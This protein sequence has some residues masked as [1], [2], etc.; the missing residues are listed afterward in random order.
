MQNGTVLRWHK[1]PA[2]TV[3]KGQ[4][5]LDVEVERAI[6]RIQADRNATVGEILAPAGTTVAVGQPLA[7]MDE[8][9]PAPAEKPSKT[10]TKEAAMAEP[11]GKVIPILMPQAGNTM[12]EGT[13]IKWHVKVGDTI[14]EGALIFDVET[15]KAAVEIEALD[16]GRLARIT[17]EE[18]EIMEVLKPVAYIADSDED[19][20]AYLASQGKAAAEP[21]QQAAAEEKAPS[22][23]AAKPQ[24]TAPAATSDSG[25]VKA[26]PAA[27]KTAAQRGVDIATVGA[28][29]GPGGRILLADVPAGPAAGAVADGA[30]RQKM[31]PMRRAIG[32]ALQT[33]KQT[34]PHFYIEL[35]VDADAMMDFYRQEKAEY[36][37]SLNDVVLLACAKTIAEFPSFRSRI[38]GEEMVTLPTANIGIAVGLEGGLVV[39]VVVA[40][41]KMNLQQVAG[42]TRRIAQA[43]R[44]GKIEGLGQGVFTISNLGMFGIERFSAIINP[45]EAAI[46][47]VGAVRE[48]VVVS[49]GAIQPGKRMTLTLSCDHRVIDGLAAAKFLDRLKQYLEMPQQLV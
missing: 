21:Q 38:D 16:S 46:L 22:S 35:T 10:K 5:L 32:K 31:S 13:I 23:P 20:D 8:A 44:D 19:L 25:R 6:I 9:A 41:E 24:A 29:S 34:I 17:V 48:E 36:K 4:P 11:K 47:A 45:P 27:R 43:A 26:S 12:E 7:R 40:A 3:E 37:C 28:G 1:A 14:K 42:E 39:P 49:D 30:T 15:D 18:G 2:E 33:S